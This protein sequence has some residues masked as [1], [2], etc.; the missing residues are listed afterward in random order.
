MN[1]FIDE[2]EWTVLLPYGLRNGAEFQTELEF[3]TGMKINFGD[4]LG[5]GFKILDADFRFGRGVP[6]IN[7]I[8]REMEGSCRN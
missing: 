8:R 5:E 3:K 1:E 6:S 2:M 7:S 4:R